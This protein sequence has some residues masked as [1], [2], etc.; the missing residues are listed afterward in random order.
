MASIKSPDTTDKARTGNALQYWL[1]C[2]KWD[3]YCKVAS[4]PNHYASSCTRDTKHAKM[5][6]VIRH[7]YLWRGGLCVSHTIQWVNP[8]L[9]FV[10]IFGAVVFELQ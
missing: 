2:S 9:S 8:C 6:S 4:E 10:T 3:L 7:S 5:H 1:L